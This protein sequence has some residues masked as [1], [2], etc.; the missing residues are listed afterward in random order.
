MDPSPVK[1]DPR[2][3][4]LSCMHTC[5]QHVLYYS[6]I[7]AGNVNAGQECNRE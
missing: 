3:Q 6:A 2:T 5:E 4:V 1:P 7:G